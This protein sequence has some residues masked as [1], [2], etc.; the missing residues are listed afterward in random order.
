MERVLA[1]LNANGVE[2]EKSEEYAHGKFV[3]IRD[4][5]GN[6]VELFEKASR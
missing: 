6:R 3:W 2:I 1:Q 5:D 4:P